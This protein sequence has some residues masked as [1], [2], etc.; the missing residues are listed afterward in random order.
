MGYMGI[1]VMRQNTSPLTFS[2]GQNVFDTKQTRDEGEIHVVEATDQR[3][4]DYHIDAPDKTIA[5]CNSDCPSD[6]RVVKILFTNELDS[7]EIGVMEKDASTKANQ[8]RDFA[9]VFTQNLRNQDKMTVYTYS[10]SR[11]KTI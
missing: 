6:D 8:G 11:L 9:A 1:P 5:E 10:E 4:E 7:Q 2:E 3:A